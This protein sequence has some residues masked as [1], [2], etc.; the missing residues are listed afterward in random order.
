ML[1]ENNYSSQKYCQ[2]CQE[3]V[4]LSST[5]IDS[6]IRKSEVA[7][8]WEQPCFN[9]KTV[10]LNQEKNAVYVH[11]TEAQIILFQIKIVPL[12]IEKSVHLT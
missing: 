10:N 8:E 7:T 5:M 4:N 12:Q 3:I 9:A 1:E 6:L 11:D 2:Q